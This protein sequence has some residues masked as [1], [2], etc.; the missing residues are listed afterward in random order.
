[1][2]IQGKHSDWVKVNTD[3]LKWEVGASLCSVLFS[4]AQ[5]SSVTVQEWSSTLSVECSF[6]M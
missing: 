6:L 5:F 3:F 4:S 1:M 2:Q